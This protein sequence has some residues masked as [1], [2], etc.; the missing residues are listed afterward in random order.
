MQSIP[1]SD[2]NNSLSFSRHS[3]ST[4]TITV[5]TPKD[6]AMT[7]VILY[8]TFVFLFVAAT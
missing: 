3:A 6:M 7:P 4:A 8:S 2:S 1:G 5:A